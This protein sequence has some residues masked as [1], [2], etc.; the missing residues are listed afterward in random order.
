MEVLQQILPVLVF[1]GLA[2]LV[3]AMTA[4]VLLFVLLGILATVPSQL[5]VKPRRTL[6][7]R[8]GVQ[9]TRP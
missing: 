1:L 6:R 2:S 5:W 4:V 8:W 3:L 7:R 9:A